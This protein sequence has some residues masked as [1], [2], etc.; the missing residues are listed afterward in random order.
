M[1]LERFVCGRT[2][3]NAYLMAGDGASGCYVVD[4]GSGASPKIWSAAQDLGLV[5][6]AVLLTHGHPDHVWSAR[7]LSDRCSA[8]VLLHALDA[9]WLDDC[10][11]GGL[12]RGV[13]HGGRLVSRLRRLRPARL[14]AVE[15]G[16]IEVAGCRVRVIHTPGHTPGG[17]CYDAGEVCFT[18]D[19]LFAGGLGHTG[20]PGG[21]G[22][23]LRRS[24]VE[25]L[26]PSLDGSVRILPGHG[27]QTTVADARRRLGTAQAQPAA[28][29]EGSAWTS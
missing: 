11:S 9:V 19:S 16:D 24:V 8:P 21:D 22:A 23:V 29:G 13:T 26:L 6:E 20:Y 28:S 10:A 1:I 2:R 3:T 27:P 14:E 18:G 12:L 25:S 17:V 7:D 5:V 15:P 4:P